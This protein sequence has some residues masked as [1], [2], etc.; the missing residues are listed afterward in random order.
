[1][2]EDL[3]LWES[4]RQ[5]DRTALADLFSLYYDL[6]ERYGRKLVREDHIL[7][8]LIH[9]VFLELW[10]RKLP[11][12]VTS[13]PSYLLGALRNRIF[14]HFR[15]TRKR[16]VSI[17]VEM[18]FQVS[19]EDFIIIREDE[20]SRIRQLVDAI[21]KLPPRQREILYLR[22][23]CDMEYAEICTLTGISYQVARNQLSNAILFIRKQS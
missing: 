22:Y 20:E 10:E 11:P 23:Y 1:M 8:D 16:S 4:F 2:Q 12:P 15:D 14:G 6:L 9:D 21:G 3:A 7:Q 19:M 18:D 5:G 17:P 13:I